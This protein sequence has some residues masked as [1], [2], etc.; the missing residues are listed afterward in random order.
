MPEEIGGGFDGGG[1][2]RWEVV[3]SDDDGGKYSTQPDPPPKKGR[4]T[5]GL[6]K[7]DGQQFKIIIKAPRGPARAAFLKQ[8]ADPPDKNDEIVLYLDRDKNSE[9]QIKVLW[10]WED[11]AARPK[12]N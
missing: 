5:K 6:D 12:A 10:Q 2:V 3:T 7:H 11:D 9:K 1:S 8:F 4:K